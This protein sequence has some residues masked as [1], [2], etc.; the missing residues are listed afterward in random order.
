M[1]KKPEQ[2]VAVTVL[3]HG[4]DLIMEERW[5]DLDNGSQDAMYAFP[6]GKPK[7]GETM[8]EAAA[9]EALEETGIAID[10]EKLS[11]RPDV[12]HADGCEGYVFNVPLAEFDTKLID[13]SV[14]IWSREDL[15]EHKEKGKLM[16]LTDKYVEDY[17]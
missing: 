2:E 16:P 3:W 14:V 8:Q 12:V 17:F 4:T 7:P 5:I 1:N 6:G 9:R 11:K 15:M 10:P 13:G